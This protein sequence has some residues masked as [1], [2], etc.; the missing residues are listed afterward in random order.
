MKIVISGAGAA[1][2]GVAKL[3][4]RAG[5][6]HLIIGDTRGIIYK[7]RVANMNPMKEWLALHTNP[8]GRRGILSGALA[9]ADVFIGV[10]VPGAVSLASVKRMAPDA[11]VFA[12]A[13]PIPEVMPEAIEGSVRIIAT[14]RS[15]YA[16]QINN[17]LCFPGMMR[18]LLDAGARSVT[19]RMLLAAAHALAGVV[20]RSELHEDYIIPSVFDRRVVSAV[21]AAVEKETLR[22]RGPA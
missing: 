19:P 11:I 9:G 5:A 16:N 22:S 8:E 15:D 17:V 6:K 21:A 3:L 4:L 2:V 12:L 1:G 14:G 18:G 13:N 20:S 7:G 10:S